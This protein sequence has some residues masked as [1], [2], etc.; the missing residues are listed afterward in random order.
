MKRTRRA[1]SSSEALYQVADLLA[2]T[3]E[4]VSSVMNA[5]VVA[6]RHYPSLQLKVMAELR[7]HPGSTLSSLARGVRLPLPRASRVCSGLEAA[8]MLSRR[9][10]VVDRREIGLELTA[11]GGSLL[12]DIAARRADAL[13]DALRQMTVRERRALAAGLR[14]LSASLDA[15]AR[16]S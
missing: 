14:S 16:G 5:A 2:D 13:V 4:T 6:D 1:D 10:S 15:E 8:G 11:A 7:E 3:A 12:K 9:P